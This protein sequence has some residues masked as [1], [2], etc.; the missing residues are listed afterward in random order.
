MACCL[1]IAGITALLVFLFGVR[2]PMGLSVAGLWGFALAA[3]AAALILDGRSRAP[4]RPW[5]GPLRALLENRRRYA[6]FLIHAGLFSLAV[7]I[8]GSSLGAQRHE[9]V[10]WE[11]EGVQWAGHSIRLA[12][13]NQR[14][15]PDRFIAEAELEITP[16]GAAPYALSPGKHLHLPSQEW[17]TEVAVRSGW[18]ADFYTILNGPEDPGQLRLTF[19]INPMMR[20]LWAAG[21]I[22]GVGTLVGLWP[23]RR[24]S[25]APTRCVCR[26]AARSAAQA[27]RCCDREDGP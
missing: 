25:A 19:L 18:T 13:V 2:Q 17:S 20:W 6:G 14:Q 26:R 21:W 27:R 1:A 8:V 3:L 11:G 23:Q 22:A 12:R 5:L 7:G 24:R 4:E 15:L 9:A 10:M 16:Q